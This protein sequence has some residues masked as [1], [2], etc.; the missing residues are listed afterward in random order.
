MPE[1]K[2]WN[3]R[4]V[5]SATLKRFES[6][7]M[8]SGKMQDRYVFPIFDG[9]NS[10]VGMAGRSLDEA[11]KPKW[12]LEG[13]KRLWAYPLKLNLSILKKEKKV[14]LVESIG[15]M[16]ALWEAGVKNTIVTFGLKVTSKIK[17]ILI[18]LSPES[19]HIA[20]NNDGNAAGNAAAT[21]AHTELLKHFDTHQISVALPS[22]N[23]FG[24]MSRDDILLWKSQHNL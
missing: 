14:I 11:K 20:F 17:Q 22:K 24:C 12:K 5:S 16:L 8:R 9:Q 21:K 18:S 6:G 2:Y 23:D 7:V 15:D 3:N 13:E 19:V 10:I 4:G 1:Y